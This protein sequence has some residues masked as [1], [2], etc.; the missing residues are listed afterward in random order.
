MT[1][2][3]TDILVKAAKDFALFAWPN[4]KGDNVFSVR[5]E[6]HNMKI[7]GTANTIREGWDIMFAHYDRVK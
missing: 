3:E 4:F 5:F 2:P 6:D 1:G 7:V